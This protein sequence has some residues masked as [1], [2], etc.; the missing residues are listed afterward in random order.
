MHCFGQLNIVYHLKLLPV[1]VIICFLEPASIF[2]TGQFQGTYWTNC[3]C[4]TEFIAPESNA[5][6]LSDSTLKQ[7]FCEKECGTSLWIFLLL[8]FLCTVASF[9]SGIPSQ[10]VL[11]FLPKIFIFK[12]FI[13]L[14]YYIS[15][16]KFFN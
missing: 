15:L 13:L 3:S 12:T 16:F 7:G 11:L 8:L 10:Q 2:K 1:I 9:A 4:L 6:D 14:L 5:S